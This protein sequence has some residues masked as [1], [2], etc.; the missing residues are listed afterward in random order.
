MSTA[1][2]CQFAFSVLLL[3]IILA[4]S[5]CFSQQTYKIGF[6]GGLTGRYSDLG[7]AG[8][9]GAVLAVEEINKAGGVHGRQV[10]LIVRDDKNDP[11]IVRAV[12]EELIDAG[13]T[14]LI[15]HMTSVAAVASLPVSASGKALIV[16]PTAT[17]DSLRGYDDML[18]TVMPPL[19][20]M[21]QV[22]A[23]YALN[24]LGLKRM[25][26]I[27]DSS[28]PEYAQNWAEVFNAYFERFGGKVVATLSFTSGSSV[29]YESLANEA[30]GYRPEGIL[31]AAGA[32]DAAVMSQWLRKSQFTVPIFSSS[33]AMTDDFI[34]HGG[35][36][37][38]GVIFSS[39]YS[40]DN[41]SPAYIQFVRRYLERFG[42]WPNYAAAYSYEAAQLVLTGI[43]SAGNDQALAVRNAIIGQQ[44]FPG[45]WDDYLIN[46]TGDASRVCRVVIVKNGQF[47]TLD[48]K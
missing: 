28:N 18:I 9:N 26:I 41:H 48:K 2:R 24:E 37:V 19:K 22:Q 40:P 31:L 6:V 27:C 42:S 12:D 45:L 43:N 16:T 46:A 15:G 10:E 47:V 20:P 4:A 11:A 3:L 1:K 33:W 5:G 25:V 23:A 44:Q 32:V 34:R 38:E 13:V 17:S 29:D 35:Q 39:S 21:A 36:A 7:V 30:A 8:R 14:I